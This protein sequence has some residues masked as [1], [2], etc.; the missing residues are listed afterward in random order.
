MDSK[1]G[2]QSS[3]DRQRQA[4]AE[5][6]RKKVLAAYAKSAQKMAN[7]AEPEVSHL[8]EEPVSPKIN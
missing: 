8:K 2:G 3:G 4:A 6:A 1:D 7:E 5:I